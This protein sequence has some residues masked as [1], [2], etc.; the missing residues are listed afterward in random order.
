MVA[1]DSVNAAISGRPAAEQEIVEFLDAQARR[2]GLATRRLAVR[3]GADNLLILCEKRD[4][5]PWVLFESH[6]DTVGTTGADADE[7]EPN[8]ARIV[9]GRGAGDAK[10]SGA[11]MLWSLKDYA[12]EPGGANNVAV[13][14]TVDEETSKSGIRAFVERHLPSLGWRPFGAVVGEPTSL[15]LVVAHKGAVRWSIRT[16]GIAAHSSDPSRGRSAIRSMM[17]VMEALETRYIS[18]LTASHPLT[19]PAA[20]SINMIQGGSEVNIIPDRC[21]I[22]IDRRTVPGEDGGHVLAE[23]DGLLEELRL[24]DPDLVA[25]IHDPWIDP[26]L[27]PIAGETFSAQVGTILRTCDLSG[28]PVGAGFGTD[29]SNLSNAG[30]Q[31]VVLGP[32][33]IAQA[34]AAREW[35]ALDQVEHAVRIYSAIMRQATA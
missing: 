15:R 9:E 8:A 10:G 21:E 5:A 3:G 18:R 32:G 22:R 30:I 23:V 29:A 31:T 13:L 1:I 2:F 19:G 11:A 27:E 26:A 17:A 33:D 24:A 28:E 12:A 20:C 4:G 34:H 25:G 14:F 16:E 35:I 7:S 6:M